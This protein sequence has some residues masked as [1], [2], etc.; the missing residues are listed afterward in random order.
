[1]RFVNIYRL[2]KTSA[3]EKFQDELVGEGGNR[4]GYR[5]L[6]T[7]LAIVTGAPH[8]SST[9]FRIL[10]NAAAAIRRAP[11]P[12]RKGDGNIRTLAA[13]CKQLSRD[14]TAVDGDQKRALLGALERLAVS[15]EEQGPDADRLLLLALDDLAPVARR[16][17]FTARQN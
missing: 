17:S 3:P 12:T 13:L 2:V 4:P 5:A 8:V 11:V 10:E 15:T 1:M 14:L 9:Y 7:Q 16:Y 6:I